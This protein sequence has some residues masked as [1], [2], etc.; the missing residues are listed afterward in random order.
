MNKKVVIGVVCAVVVLIL[1]WVGIVASQVGSEASALHDMLEAKLKD[2]VSRE[3]LQ[4]ALSAK[5]FTVEPAPAFRATG[6]KHTMVV[7]TTWLTVTAE[8]SA[9]NKMSGYHMDRAS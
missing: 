1:G 2:H 6:P 5:G 3:D 4:A 8:F 9:E 7:Y